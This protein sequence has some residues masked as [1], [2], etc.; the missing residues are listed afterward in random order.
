MTPLDYLVTPFGFLDDLWNRVWIDEVEVWVYIDTTI[1]I[2]AT[3]LAVCLLPVIP[4]QK[5]FR[6]ARLWQRFGV[7][8]VGT[9]MF[10]VFVGHLAGAY[11]TIRFVELIL[12][13]AVLLSFMTGFVVRIKITAWERLHKIVQQEVEAERHSHD[14]ET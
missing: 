5:G 2:A 12:H 1:C 14:M 11:V 7:A 13:S 9:S 3:I 8:M 4:I 6:Q 10:A